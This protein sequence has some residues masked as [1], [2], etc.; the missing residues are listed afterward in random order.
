M[1]KIII[2]IVAVLLLT[3]PVSALEITAPAVPG[4]AADVM[5]EEPETFAEG[6]WELFKAVI[7]KVRPEIGDAARVCLSVVAACLM[8]SVLH[9][10][11]GRGKIVAEL[12]CTVSIALILMTPTQTFVKLGIQTVE[13]MINYGKLLLPVMTA[14]LAAQGGI[15]RSAA[16]YTGSAVFHTVLGYL[17]VSLMVPAVN[18]FLALAVANSAIGDETLKKIRDFIKWCATWVLK[19]GLYIFSGYMS[20]TGVIT[21]SADAAALKVT[22]STIS[23]AVPVIGNILSEASET[24]LIGAAVV[25]NAAGIYG[26]LAILALCLGPFIRIGIQYVLLKVTAVICSVFA[27]KQATELIGDFSAAMGLLL[28]VTGTICLMLLISTVCFMKGVA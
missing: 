27:T 13:E 15:T 25:K 23:L 28:A 19:I 1:K 7:I 12:I 17:I 2:L 5:P 3:K 11:T 20:L 14:G 18:I 6:L 16:L 4:S 9:P 10:M 24:V 26:M 21:G 22:K 8:I